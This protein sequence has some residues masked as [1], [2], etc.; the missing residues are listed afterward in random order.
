MGPLQFHAGC[1]SQRGD[2]HSTEWPV[3]EGEIAAPRYQGGSDTAQGIIVSTSGSSFQ[4]PAAI[5]G[6][7]PSVAKCSA[8]VSDQSRGFSWASVDADQAHVVDSR[9]DPL[10]VG[11]SALFAED[12]GDAFADGDGCAS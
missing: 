7:D 10:S 8:R 4:S 1:S 6:V 2:D 12:G 9:V 11:L 5:Q 3:V